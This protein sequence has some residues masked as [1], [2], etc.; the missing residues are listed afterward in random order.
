MR[1]S[2]SPFRN[3]MAL[4]LCLQLQACLQIKKKGVEENK[5]SPSTPVS[6]SSPPPAPEVLA[7]NEYFVTRLEG[8]SQPSQYR[9][10]IQLHSAPQL[11][12]RIQKTIGDGIETRDFPVGETELQDET[13]KSGDQVR[14]DLGFVVGGRFQ[15]TKTEIIKVPL[16]FEF[17]ANSKLDED[18]LKTLPFKTE[19]RSGKKWLLLEDFERVF[20]PKDSF[21]FT[22]DHNLE[23]K[24]KE[25]YFHRSLIATFPEGAKAELS[26][27]GRSGGHLRIE[28]H[29]AIGDVRVELRGEEGGDGLP[30][31]PPD[32]RNKGVD[33][34]SHVP[35]MFT[36]SNLP[37]YDSTYCFGGSRTIYTC[38]TPVPVGQDADHGK[39]GH[40]GQPGKAGGNTGKIHFQVQDFKDLELLLLKEVGLGGQGG[41]GAAGGEPGK[42]GLA[43]KPPGETQNC[44]PFVDGQP[45][46]RG[47]VGDPGDDGSPGRI[48]TSC[49][50]EDGKITC[51]NK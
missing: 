23:I 11:P 21:L 50:P 30:G 26:K 8:T 35:P 24:T 17:P 40:S 43:W 39:Q 36:V 29:R 41:A 16:D 15:V 28:A 47:F 5:T 12:V 14:F 42:P 7:Q 22:Q 45:G 6:E 31:D 34:P 3:I 27:E 33:R 4:A 2:P 18:T 51:S 1:R 10:H 20:M 32:A 19:E 9:L 46:K 49:Y 48:E 13:L 38:T 44:Q 25:I 37:C